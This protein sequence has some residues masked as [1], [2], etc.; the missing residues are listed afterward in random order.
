MKWYFFKTLK[1]KH[2][3]IKAL[4]KGSLIPFIKYC[5]YRFQISHFLFLKRKWYMMRVWYSPYAFWLWNHEDKEKDEELFFES[6]LKSGDVVVDC[7]AHLGTLSIIASKIVGGTGKVVACEAHPRTFSFLSKNIQENKCTN[8]T[9]LNVALSDTEGKES[10]ADYYA[11]DLNGID[12]DGTVVVTTT[13]LDTLLCD[14]K[15]ISLLK[16]DIEGSE[17]P[18][19]RAAKET[20]TKTKAVYFESAEKSFARFGYSLF[21]VVSFLHKEGFV[22]YRTC[23]AEIGEEVKEGYITKT[24]YENMIALRA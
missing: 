12:R 21:D 8:T 15:E 14:I 16:L 13:T 19:L 6:F 7:G 2:F 17:L 3:V 24:R 20:L 10:F 11:N 22:V 18:A 5:L 4:K 23:G 9:C 1:E